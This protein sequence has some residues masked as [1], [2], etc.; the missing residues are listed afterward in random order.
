MFFQISLENIALFIENSHWIFASI[1]TFLIGIFY[2]KRSAKKKNTIYLQEW[3][4]S[5]KPAII[6]NLIL[7]LI[8]IMVSYLLNYYFIKTGM[9]GLFIRIFTYI[10]IYVVL[11]VFI[12]SLII[13]KYYK[14]K[15]GEAFDFN[16]KIQAILF[17]TC[18]IFAIFIFLITI[19]PYIFLFIIIVGLPNTLVLTSLGLIWGFLIGIMLAIMRVYGG[20]ELRWFATG[21]ENLFRGIPLLVLIY[22][23]AYGV[24]FLSP[25]ESMVVALAL[26]SGA[27]QSQIFR[28][29]ML[30]V[31]PGQ[32]DAAYTIGMNR[33]Q[34]FRYILMPQALRLS[35]PS[36]SNEYAIVIKDSSLS[37]EV[38]V[39]EMTRAAYYISVSYKELFS[40]SLGVAAIIYF[41][42]T[43][44]IIKLIGERQ[45]NKLKKLGMGGG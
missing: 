12:G 15:V 5:I 45:T 26:R 31:N 2:M 32:V 14:K 30:S 36:W 34:A 3:D 38:G 22:L 44:P 4:I 20:V 13:A 19:P 10:E 11:D 24:P 9:L 28:G 27:Y 37:Y 25:L 35:L 39:I 1:I 42:F 16:I 18:L 21:Y 33:F 41:L 7:L 6:V 29:A 40:L 43:Y 17:I 8:N 23:F